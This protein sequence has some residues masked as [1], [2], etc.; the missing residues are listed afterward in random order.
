MT[1]WALLIVELVDPLMEIVDRETG[2]FSDCPHCLKATSSV[3]RANVLLFKTVIAGDSWGQIAVPLIEA[4][5]LTAI[6]FMGSLLTLVFGVMN[7]I[8]QPLVVDTL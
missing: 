2:A 8:A 1:V 6:I 5:P 3:M 7:L 4:Y